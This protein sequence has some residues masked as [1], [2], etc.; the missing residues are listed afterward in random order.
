MAT[1]TVPDE[2]LSRFGR[3]AEEMEQFE[4]DEEMV[5]FVLSEVAAELEG[6]VSNRQKTDGD[7]DIEEHLEEMGYI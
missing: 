7:E 5:R 2:L 1:V 6:S 3:L 4:T